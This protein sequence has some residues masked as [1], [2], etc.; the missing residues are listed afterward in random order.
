MNLGGFS[1]WFSGIGWCLTR[2]GVLWVTVPGVCC[3]GLFVWW[4]F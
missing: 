1:D 4:L 3:S 2:V